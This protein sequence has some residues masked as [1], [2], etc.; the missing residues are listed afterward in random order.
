ASHVFTAPHTPPAHVSMGTS[1]TGP[2]DVGAP[3]EVAAPP[4]PVAD[5]A[6]APPGVA[7]DELESSPPPHAA[8]PML[9]TPR[10]RTSARREPNF[11]IADKPRSGTYRVVA[12][13]HVDHLSRRGGEP[14]GHQ[15]DARLRHRGR[16]VDVP[17]ERRAVGPHVLEA[18]EA[19]DR[20]RGQRAD[21]LRRDQVHPD[22][23]AAE[24][25]C[26]VARRR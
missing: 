20:L 3:P 16:V 18:R 25:A 26:E 1:P 23:L 9:P 19:G 11:D 17:P 24:L 13:V 5:E 21:R 10:T 4:V 14:V 22:A 15:R 8:R 12:T 2:A 7:A 6:V